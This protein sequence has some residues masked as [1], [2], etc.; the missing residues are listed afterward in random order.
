MHECLSLIVSKHLILERS[1]ENM[2]KRTMA[3]NI[4]MLGTPIDDQFEYLEQIV[5][6]RQNLCN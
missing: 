3:S 5:A 6:A 1:V 2:L 4:P